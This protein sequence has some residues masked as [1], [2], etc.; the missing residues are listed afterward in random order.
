MIFPKK[1]STLESNFQKN[2]S[3][4]YFKVFDSAPFWLWEKDKENRFVRV[5]NSFAEALQ[6]KQNDLKGKSYYDI[7]SKEQAKILW[8]EDEGIVATGKPKRNI[9]ESF[10]L[11]IGDRTVRTDKYPIY[12]EEGNVLGIIGFSIDITEQ[13]TGKSDSQENEEL[14]KKSK[15]FA[16]SRKALMNILEDVEQASA[17]LARERDKTLA[18]ISNIYT[19]VIVLDKDN[20]ITLF[21]PSAEKFLGMQAADLGMKISSEKNFSINNFKPVIRNKIISYKVQKNESST[22]ITEELRIEHNKEQLVYKVITSNVVGENGQFLGIMKIFYDL[23]REAEIDKLKS[24]FVSVAAH[25]LRTPLSAIKWIIK[26]VIDGDAGKLNPEQLELLQRGYKS[27]ER[28]IKLVDDLLN[29]SRIEEGRFGFVFKDADFGEILDTVVD[30]S[31]SVIAKNHLKLIVNKPKIL[32]KI[33]MD[34]ERIILVFQNLVDNAAKYTPEFGQIQITLE[35]LEKEGVLKTSIK[36]QG[37]G[38]PKADQAKL[39][40]KFFRAANAVRLE[41]EGTG[42]GLFIAKNIVEKHDGN[43]GIESEE[44]KGTEVFFSLPLHST[45]I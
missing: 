17:E 7:F 38:I 39:F 9:I 24:E 41:T 8:R 15:E 36:D 16:Q 4:E 18:I 12:N 32:P 30:N 6:K 29:V 33:H 28:V 22:L 14:K 42:L 37:V 3:E 25:Q 44:G 19:P 35:V 13:A 10:K 34:P 20:K 1:N 2:I 27:N 5:N 21:N 45:K 23:T 31:A 26:M 11:P 40:S 43:I